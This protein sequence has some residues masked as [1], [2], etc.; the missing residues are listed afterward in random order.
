[1]ESRLYRSQ[2]ALAANGVRR[3]YGA[4]LPTHHCSASSTF[5]GRPMTELHVVT[6]LLESRALGSLVKGDVWLKMETLQPSG[7][8]KIRGIGHA[9][10]TYVERGAKRLI[11]SSGGNAGLAVAYA[12][13]RLDTP[14][15]VVVPQ[16]TTKRAIELIQLEQAEVVIHGESWNEA[17]LHAIE[18]STDDQSYIHPFDDPLIWTGHATVIDEIRNYGLRPDLV[19]LSVGGGGLFCGVVEG[20][21][22]NDFASTAI[23]AVET[24]GADSLH[25]SLNAGRLVELERIS[26]IATSLGA[27]KI[28]QRAFE[29]AQGGNVFSEIVDDCAAVRACERFLEDHRVLVEPACGAA[30]AVFYDQLGLLNRFKTMVIIVCGGVGVTLDQL[31]QWKRENT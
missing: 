15:T 28:A 23:L 21:R 10:R 26:S 17:H 18:I 31:Q 6:P 22:R 14:V 12:G 3:C 9:C 25:Q 30:L 4:D 7:S 8:F 11:A 27:K 5:V 24:V 29:Y 13:R 2:K 1:M 20:L 19:V 16:S